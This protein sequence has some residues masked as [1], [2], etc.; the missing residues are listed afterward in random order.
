MKKTIFAVG[1]SVLAIAVLATGCRNNSNTDMS[2]V[3]ETQGV[4]AAPISNTA[5]RTTQRET[6]NNS[7][8]MREDVED[9]RDMAREK[10]DAAKDAAHDVAD[11]LKDAGRDVADGMKDAGKDMKNTMDVSDGTPGA[12]ITDKAEELYETT[13][14][15][16]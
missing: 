3:S 11:G 4:T 12:G 14:V 15:K 8:R 7:E 9:L 13:T 16:R 5:P 6:E 1:L 10:K 2:G